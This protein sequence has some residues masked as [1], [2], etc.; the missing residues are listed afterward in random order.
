[1]K[2]LILASAAAALTLPA[3]AAYADPPPWAPADGKRAHRVYDS[4]GYYIEPRPLTRRD[5][6]WRGR[7]GRYYCRRDNGTTGLVIGAAVGGLLGN[8]IAG[9]GDKTLGTIIGAVG[10][11]L[12]GRAIDRGELK[13]R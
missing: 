5:R 3:S 1:M 10:G 9:D 4:R 13:C 12:L 11:G 2:N 6:V 8:R 7:D